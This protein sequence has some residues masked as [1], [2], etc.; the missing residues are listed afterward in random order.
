MDRVVAVLGASGFLGASIAKRLVG[1]GARVRAYSHTDGDIRDAE[2][3]RPVLADAE[4]IF[5]LAGHSGAIASVTDPRTD[6]EVNVGGL[7]T[8]LECAA[9]AKRPPK[10]VFPGSRLE[11]G[12]VDSVPVAEDRA[13]RPN[14]PYAA[15]KVLC[16]H[17][18]EL[19]AQR[20]GM[21]YAIARLTNPYGVLP[22]SK[23]HG[24]NVLSHFI[25]QAL[26]GEEISIYGGGE[27]MRDYI[28]IEDAVDALLFLGARTDE[29]I[30]VNVGSGTGTRLIDAARTI[31]A[32]AGRGR[33]ISI[34]WPNDARNV[35]TGDF[36]A[37]ITRIRALGWNPATSF[38]EG[39]RMTVDAMRGL[40]A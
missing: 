30:V 5:A 18:L 22:E 33:V 13:L 38:Q 6:L 27:Q 32:V 9:A 17:Y 21:R 29:N 4:V 8:V 20:F 19:Y 40:P 11:Y 1:A 7:L 16:E 12:H 2:R 36:V 31:V 34:P 25:A 26:A 39:I 24:Y 15:H 37:D 14:S 35:E 3:L 23:W 28:Y 10:V